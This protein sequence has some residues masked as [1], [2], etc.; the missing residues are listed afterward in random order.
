MGARTFD[1]TSP[2]YGDNS[3]AIMTS[4]GWAEAVR[5]IAIAVN[6]A[7]AK[8]IWRHLNK[9]LQF[10]DYDQTGQYCM[11]VSRTYC[12]NHEDFEHEYNPLYD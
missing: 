2:L 12:T 8:S 3:V 10:N 4:F 11:V 7:I 6:D 5:P 9:T 1:N